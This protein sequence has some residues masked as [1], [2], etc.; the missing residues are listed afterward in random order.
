MSARSA[1]PADLLIRPLDHRNREE[2]A[3]F[4]RVYVD[5]ERAEFADAALYSLEEAVVM[6]ESPRA[7]ELSLGYVAMRGDRM[8][9]EALIIGSLT[10]N[11]TT[12]FLMVWVAPKDSRQGVGTALVEHL[13][14]E[15]RRLGRTVLQGSARYPFSRRDDHPYRRFAE[16]NG[17][18]L[19]NTEVERRLALPVPADLL[20]RLAAEAQPF[21][22]AY[23]IVTFVGP[24]PPE[25][26]QGFCDVV[27]R[28]AVD[29]P[30]GD[31]VSEEERRTPL[32]L[33]DQDRQ[34][35]EAGRTR[36]SA[37]AL[38]PAGRVVAMT[39]AGITAA[40]QPHVSQWATIVLPEHRGHRLG[41]ALKVANLRLVQERF[42]EK[43]YVRTTNAETNA[44]MVDIN[45]RLGFE[46][47]A[48]EGEFQRIL[49]D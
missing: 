23:R 19:A 10:D 27:N 11:L 8:V 34:I 1:R 46:I 48:L 13:A 30:H 15:C 6:F 28:L 22:D 14:A 21:H 36:V 42:P 17:F 37:V 39:S 3:A 16:K 26:A 38:D 40:D 35:I 18:R 9:G 25:Y 41:M 43:S 20:D 4:Q 49:D 7:D 2:L 45:E 47:Y 29:A 12:A 31:L 32:T 33:A 44:A 5:A 24:V